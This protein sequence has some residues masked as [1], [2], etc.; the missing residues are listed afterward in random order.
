LTTCSTARIESGINLRYT[1]VNLR[2]RSIA[3]AQ[4]PP[5]LEE[6]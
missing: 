5:Q 2:Y 1:D 3:G 4:L 6:K